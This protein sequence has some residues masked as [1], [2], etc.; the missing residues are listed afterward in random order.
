MSAMGQKRTYAVHQRMSANG[1]K[2]TLNASDEC[3]PYRK[4]DIGGRQTR[5]M[6]CV[7]EIAC[8]IELL[9]AT[10]A[11]TRFRTKSAANMGSTQDD[12]R[13]FWFM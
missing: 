11:A 13:I 1:H 7:A 6:L 9:L 5:K 12:G 10:I 4:E 2:R 8:G 3:P